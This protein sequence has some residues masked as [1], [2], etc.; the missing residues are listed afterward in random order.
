MSIIFALYTSDAGFA[1]LGKVLH[2]DVPRYALDFCVV[3]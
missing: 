1:I 2:K 3:Y